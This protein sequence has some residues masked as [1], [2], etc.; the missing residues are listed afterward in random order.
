MKSKLLL[1]LGLAFA[2][3]TT[4]K[5]LAQTSPINW[6][7]FYIGGN[8]GYGWGAADSSQSGGASNFSGAPVAA[9]W[10]SL[11]IASTAGKAATDHVLGGVQA[12]YNFSSNRWIIGAEADLQFGRQAG[13]AFLASSL[14]G[15]MCNTVVLPAPGT[16]AFTPG[17]PI[18]VNGPVSTV[19]ESSIDWFGTI[20][21]RLGYLLNDNLLVFGTGGLAYG[22]VNVSATTNAETSGTGGQMFGPGSAFATLSK[23]N[24]GFALGGGLEG[25]FLPLSTNWTWKVEYL[26]VDLG[27]IDI[28]APFALART[29]SASPYLT[30]INGTIATHTRF[31]ENIIRIG[32]NYRFTP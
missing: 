26:Y 22:R 24:I 4:S 8:V 16:C 2:I 7:G 9:V 32:L 20:R 19:L 5:A 27:S 10:N 1:A 23:T 12:G 25:S 13:N 14:S 18:P 30:T 15:V 6:S 17:L 21:G 31:T 3:A 29:D 11:N 28:V